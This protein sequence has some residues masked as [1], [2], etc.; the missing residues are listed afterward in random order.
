MQVADYLRPSGASNWVRCFGYAQLNARIGAPFEED[1]DT[2]VREDGTA[3]HW[4]A[5]Q[6]LEGIEHATDT[7]AP[8]GRLITNEMQSTVGEYVSI[9]NAINA[10][11]YWNIEGKVPVSRLFAGV[12]DGTPDAWYFDHVNGVLYVL[13]LKFGFRYVDAYENL[14]LVIYALTILHAVLNVSVDDVKVKLGIF[15]P[16]SP[17]HEGPLRWWSPTAAKLHELQGVIQN[18]AYRAMLP[19]AVCT[20]HPGCKHCPGAHGCHALRMAASQ[21]T[22][23]AYAAVPAVMDNERLGFELSIRHKAMRMLES[24]VTALETQA[25]HA[26]KHGQRVMGYELSP[27]RTLWRWK[28]GAQERLAAL[29]GLLKIEVTEVKT[30]SVAQLRAL[31]PKPL[32]EMYAEKPNGGLQ[33]K[34]IDP[35]DAERRFNQE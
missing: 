13:D 20:P 18:A 9:I 7:V 6:A 5:Q 22:E 32:L 2:E 35:K 12:Q 31:L 19:S 16:R 27:R 25:E 11:V 34:A 33:L 24:Q 23:V 17:N 26:L 10:W 1:E 8:N 29:A 21:A 15:Q 4:L 30:K 3:C 14:Q 28:E